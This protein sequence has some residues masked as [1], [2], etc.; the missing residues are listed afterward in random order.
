LA[1]DTRLP[2]FYAVAARLSRA[3]GQIRREREKFKSRPGEPMEK[4]KRREIG[5]IWGLF[6]FGM[7]VGGVLAFALMSFFLQKGNNDR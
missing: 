7:L 6:Y 1:G 5:L 4:K 3:G 2:I